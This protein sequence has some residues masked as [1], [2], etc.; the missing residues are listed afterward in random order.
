[1]RHHRFFASLAVAVTA[2]ATLGAFAITASA[3]VP[4]KSAPFCAGKT[5]KDAVKGIKNAYNKVLNGSL[6]LTLDQK[7]AYVQ[8]SSDP[9]FNSVL[10][11]IANKNAAML[12]TT[13]ARVYT[14]TCTGRKT[15]N[16][17][18]DLLLAGKVSAGL[19]PAGSAILDGKV[20]KIT[21]VT[22]CN[23]FTLADPTLASNGPCAT[24]LSKG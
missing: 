7:F 10:H 24:V 18:W 5:K 4:T 3:S 22:V 11:D 21:Q 13:N 2:V 17:K 14:V 8:G 12:K 19:A 23:L 6:S 15:A 20:W 1:V 9:A 16:V